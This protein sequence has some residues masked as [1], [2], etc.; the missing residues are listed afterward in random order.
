MLI[1][2]KMFLEG[3]WSGRI[4]RGWVFH[5]K[6]MFVSLNQDVSTVYKETVDRVPNLC[7]LIDNAFLNLPVSRM[8]NVL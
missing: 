4:V 5:S 8:L 7:L 2:E 1:W 6:P 3:L